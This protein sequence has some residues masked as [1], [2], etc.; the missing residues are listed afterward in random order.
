MQEFL[1]RS[2]QVKK[3]EGSLL[4]WAVREV[5][6]RRACGSLSWKSWTLPSGL[7]EVAAILRLFYASNDPQASILP[8]SGG[9][10]LLNLAGEGGR[11][12]VSQSALGQAPGVNVQ[13]GT[14]LGPLGCTSSLQSP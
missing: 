1:T 2:L 12:S 14:V 8:P 3:A 9:P 13:A 11:A 10:W 4:M 6:S 5:S 7:G